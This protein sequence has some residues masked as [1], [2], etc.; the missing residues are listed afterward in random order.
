MSIRTNKKYAPLSSVVRMDSERVIADGEDGLLA[1]TVSETNL[2]AATAGDAGNQLDAVATTASGNFFSEVSFG[3]DGVGSVDAVAIGGTS[4]AVIGAADQVITSADLG[5]A[6]GLWTLTVNVGGV[7]GAYTFTLLDNTAHAGNDL[8]GAADT[9]AVP[10]ITATV[11]DG[12]G[13]TVAVSLDIDIEDDGPVAVDDTAN[14]TEGET[15]VG[16][17]LLGDDNQA[18]TA[19]DD[20]FGADGADSPFAITKITVLDTDGMPVGPASTRLRM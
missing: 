3:A 8:V 20:A 1:G 5:E 4:V 17:V 15:V 6:A 18:D 9:V 16:N 11:S 2:L 13:D 14:V 10:T 7:A 12:D 19:D